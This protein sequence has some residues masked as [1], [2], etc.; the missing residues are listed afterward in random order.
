MSAAAAGVRERDSVGTFEDLHEA[1]TR[2]TGLE[3]FG[4]DEYHEPLRVLLDS[5]A[6][7][8][9][10]TGVGNTMQ[11]SFMRGALAARL[12]SQKAFADRPDHADVPLERP[13]FVT[14][15]QRSGT[16]AVQRLLHAVPDAQGLEM[17]LTQV[18]Q[19]RPPRDTWEADPVH[20]MLA[21]GFE[22]HHEENPEYAGIHWMTA[23]TVEECWQLL[24]QSL[25]TAAYP[26]LAHVPEYSAWLRKA[27][28]VPA[29]ERYR[30]NLQLIGLNDVGKRWV[31]KNPSHLDALD[32]LMTVFPDAL[33]VQTHRDPVVC[34][35]SACSLAASTT[36][37]WS[38][39]F[40][41]EQLGADVLAM[42][43]TEAR[44]FAEARSRYDAARFVDVQYDDLVADPVGVV[45][46]IH[47]QWDLPWSDDV[48]AAVA[49]EHAASRSGPRAPRHTYAL[50]DHGLTADQVRAA[51]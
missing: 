8:A 12:L 41:G 42:L 29:Y 6:S 14:G 51:F 16:T 32:A 20:A 13:V 24:R 28:W 30:R 26:A 21:A 5:F 44:V 22:Q 39:V 47:R 50:E 38:T 33:V 9:G 1:A 11:R 45:R 49:A 19:P 3:D 34:V 36:P 37:G 2:M 35:A 10:L 27:D 31:L 25:T 7:S 23:D 40:V 48:E 4:D 15:I 46:G 18:P 17:W 43:S